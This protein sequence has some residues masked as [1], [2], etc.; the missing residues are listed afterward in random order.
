MKMEIVLMAELE[1]RTGG[2]E[3][4]Q[5]RGEGKGPQGPL[6]TEEM[7]RAQRLR[8]AETPRRDGQDQ[9]NLKPGQ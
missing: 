6:T 1:I 4:R 9:N 2:G 8:T 7:S 3:M 5:G